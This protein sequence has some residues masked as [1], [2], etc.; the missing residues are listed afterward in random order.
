MESKHR[1]LQTIFPGEERGDSITP[2]ESKKGPGY[3]YMYRVANVIYIYISSVASILL[4]RL[5]VED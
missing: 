5:I 2:L 3:V 4:H 1:R